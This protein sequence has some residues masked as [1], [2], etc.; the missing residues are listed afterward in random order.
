MNETMKPVESN[1]QLPPY[2]P[3]TISKHAMYYQV[4]PN[5]GA[6]FDPKKGIGALFKK[7]ESIV[8]SESGL[9]NSP[10]S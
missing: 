8:R 4:T 5:K 6:W 1:V 10:S 2:E 3:P 7:Q 9:P